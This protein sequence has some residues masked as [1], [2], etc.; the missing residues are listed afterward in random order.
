MVRWSPFLAVALVLALAGGAGCSLSKSSKSISASVSSPFKWSSAS[1][2]PDGDD[3]AEESA[4]RDDVRD[5]TVSYAR[6]NDEPAGLR[7]GLGQVAQRHGLTD[8]EAADGTYLA[9]GR[10]LAEA[11]LGEGELARYARVLASDDGARAA[12]VWSG[13]AAAR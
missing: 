13:W 12:L 3:E 4:Y 2:S 1:S 9:V 11:G 6:A 10:G 8:W 5:F 7:D